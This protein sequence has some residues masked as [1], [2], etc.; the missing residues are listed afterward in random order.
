MPVFEALGLG[1]RLQLVARRGVLLQNKW[2]KLRFAECLVC[3]AVKVLEM[4]GNLAGKSTGPM[5][6]DLHAWEAVGRGE[7]KS[8]YVK[9]G[10]D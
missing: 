1:T 5:K 6:Q 4:V 7:Y 2:I 9:I 10:V 3:F 8:I